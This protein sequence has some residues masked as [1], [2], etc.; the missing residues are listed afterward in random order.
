MCALKQHIAK[1]MVFVTLLLNQTKHN[2]S[3]PRLEAS[4][5]REFAKMIA[6]L[7]SNGWETVLMITG[8]ILM[9]MKGISV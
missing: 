6:G 9:I 2:L 4:E 5:T 1:Y 8:T 7:Y 3:R